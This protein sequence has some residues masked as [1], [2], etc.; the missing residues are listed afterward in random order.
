M[1]EEKHHTKGFFLFVSCV[2]DQI[3]DHEL[4][5]AICGKKSAC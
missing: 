2:R 1:A 4:G 3:H 5:C